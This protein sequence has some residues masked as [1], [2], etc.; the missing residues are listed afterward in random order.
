M[1]IERAWGLIAA[2]TN[3]KSDPFVCL[4]GRGRIP[5]GYEVKTKIIQQTLSPSWKQHFKIPLP[6]KAGVPTVLCFTVFDHDKFSSNDFLGYAE[7]SLTAQDIEVLALKNRTYILTLAG[8]KDKNDTTLLRTKGDLGELQVCKT[9]CLIIRGVEKCSF[10]LLDG[11]GGNDVVVERCL[12]DAKGEGGCVGCDSLVQYCFYFQ[13]D[14]WGSFVMI[15]VAI[16]I[17]RGEK[18]KKSFH[19]HRSP[20]ARS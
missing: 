19:I 10:I 4:S 7:V 15:I 12:C 1:S 9:L 5:P 2:D 11:G 8:R 16:Y 14:F 18:Y 17:L 3:G 20:S 13:I 6:G